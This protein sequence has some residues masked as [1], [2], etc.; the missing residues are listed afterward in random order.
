MKEQSFGENAAYATGIFIDDEE[1]GQWR[2]MLTGL[3]EYDYISDIGFNDSITAS[4]VATFIEQ[5]TAERLVH[6][7]KDYQGRYVVMVVDKSK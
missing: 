6:I 1:R 3:S 5:G 2:G 4:G 7:N